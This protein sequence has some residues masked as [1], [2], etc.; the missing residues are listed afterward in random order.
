[1]HS[2][3]KKRYEEAVFLLKRACEL[4][5]LNPDVFYNLGNVYKDEELWDSAIACYEKTLELSSSYPEALN[6]LGLCLKE[7]E[8]YD[9]SVDVLHRAICIRPGFAGAWLN[10]GNTLR[11]QSRFTEAIASYRKAIEI[12]PGIVYAYLNLGIIF[13]DQ[14]EIAEAINSYRSAIKM[15]P[16][17]IEAYLNLG[18]VL[19][20]CDKLEE[21]I[22]IYSRLIEIDP[23]C[24]DAHLNLGNALIEQGAIEEAI[25]HY[26]IA[27][28]LQ[29]DSVPA[30]FSLATSLHQENKIAEAMFFYEKALVIDEEFS[31]CFFHLSFA[32]IYS[33]LKDFQELRYQLS[34]LTT[35]QAASSEAAAC[36]IDYLS[37][38]CHIHDH[39][40]GLYVDTQPS[41]G[42]PP[43]VSTNLAIGDEFDDVLRLYASLR[44]KVYARWI[45]FKNCSASLLVLSDYLEYLRHS[46]RINSKRY[47]FV[48]SMQLSC[49]GIS[50]LID[51]PPDYLFKRLN[52]L[53]E[54]DWLFGERWQF[55]DVCAALS[56]SDSCLKQTLVSDISRS[57]QSEFFRKGH[58]LD[59]H[60]FYLPESDPCVHGISELF[61]FHGLIVECIHE[62]PELKSVVDLGYY[63]CGI[64]RAGLNLGLRRYCIEPSLH[65]ASWIDSFGLA[66]VLPEV[67][68]RCIRTFDEYMNQISRVSLDDPSTA[69]S[70]VSFIL[71]MFEYQ[72]CVQLLSLIRK[73]SD[74]LIIADDIF[75]TYSSFS[76]LRKVSSGDRM[77]LCH[78][79][80]NLL[81]DSGWQIHKT[82][83]VN[84][85]RYA[86]GIIVASSA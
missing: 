18:V 83:F 17:F 51:S 27:I 39:D 23:D 12:E 84:G 29:P 55:P 41:Q 86:S 31:H 70:V 53:L 20:G 78:N 63:S 76:V 15:R 85:V 77:N 32:T 19:K 30:F 16:D 67:P 3:A 73:F 59:A 74:N 82:W 48:K 2:K 56:L 13:K 43:C 5:P 62:N 66:N 75:N 79:Y 47:S 26:R 52:F 54:K 21:A 60:S 61:R 57:D 14:G 80:S 65:H 28:K 25:E 58:L 42:F 68:L 36:L 35:S 71:Q 40:L 81:T 33:P 7:I 1:M 10:L 6:N 37:V 4:Q 50:E 11:E 72:Q 69:L 22:V 9:Y 24:S 44:N 64:F 49:C 38:F 46:G 45:V 34:L 8:R